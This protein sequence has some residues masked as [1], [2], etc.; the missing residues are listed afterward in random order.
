MLANALGFG[1]LLVLGADASA[2]PYPR[3][4]LLIEPPALAKQ[5][6]AFRVLDVRS[7]EEYAKGHVPG[8]VRVDP[9]TWAKAFAAGQ[10]PAEWAKKIGGLGIGDRARVVLYDDVKSKDAARVWWILRYWGVDDARLLNGGWA[11]WSKAGLPVSKEATRPQPRAFAVARPE[12][13]RRATKAEI[14]DLLPK[15][16][17]QIIDSRSEAEYHG[18]KKLARRGGAI[19][20]ALHLEWT[21]AIDPRTQRFKSPEELTKIFRAAGIDPTRP[22]VTYCQSGGRAAVL[23]FTLELMGG[24]DV[25]N[26]YRS[27]AE[28]GN[29]PDTPV[30]KK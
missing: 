6:D 19:P 26:Y 8:A 16:K 1:L 23:A 24:R 10:D 21:K 20:G 29:D 27:W 12:E 3:G 5:A 7:E 13:R 17:T 9:E 22:S 30:M 14:L 18:E 15:G 28:W 25:G 2:A 11:G 4:E